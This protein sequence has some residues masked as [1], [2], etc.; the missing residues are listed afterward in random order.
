MQNH[1]VLLGDNMYY[2]EKKE[3]VLA[4]LKSRT[5]GLTSIEVNERFNKNKTNELKKTKHKTIWKILINQL[6]DAMVLIL[7]IA[8]ILSFI[9]K[10]NL[11]GIIILIIIFIDTII[12]IMQEYKAENAI[13]SLKELS[14]NYTKVLRNNN[15]TSVLSKNI[16]VGDIIVL[17]EGDLIPA[18]MRLI[19]SSGLRVIESSLTGESLAVNKNA[20]V[21]LDSST[22]LADRINM[23]YAS[24]LVTYGHGLGIVTKIG[25][26]TEVGHIA[27]ML[28]NQGE[29][30]TPLKKK[31]ESVG[32]ILSIIG[33]V[34]CAMLFI[35][36]IINGQDFE[37][38]LLT[39]M[40]LAI[41]IIPE[42]LPATATIVLAIGVERMAKKQVLI[43][44]L[45]SVETLGS[46]SVICSDKTGTLTQNKMN[47]VKI[48]TNNKF[49]LEKCMALCNNVKKQNNDFIGDPTEVALAE[50]LNQKYMQI[51]NIYERLKEL[52]FDS[53]RKKMT[54]LVKKD[55][56][57]V[58]TK[59]AAEEILPNCS[60]EYIENAKEIMSDN[61][62]KEII[63]KCNEF[64][65]KACRVLVF[66]KKESRLNDFINLDN[67]LT[68]IGLVAMVDPPR[69]DV[70]NIL[71][72]TKKA[73]IRTAIITGDNPLTA[74]TVAKEIGA[75]ENKAITGYDLM[76]IDDKQLGE[77]TKNHNIFARV[78]PY[79]KLRIVKAFKSNGEVVAMIGDGVNDAPSLKAA[80]I[81]IA[82]G[83]SGTDVAKDASDM[84]LL[85][86]D[87]PSLVDAIFEG[88]K[89]F[90]NI[91]K[92]IQFL[93][94]GNVGEILTLVIAM[95]LGFRFMPVTAI[96]ILWVNLATDT[97]PALALGVDP[98]T[99]DILLEKPKRNDSFLDKSLIKR[100]IFNGLI[101]AT[102]TLLSYFLGFR[103]NLMAGYDFDFSNVK[104]QTMAFCVLAFSQLIHS[105]NQRSNK[106]SAF[107][108]SN[109]HNKYLIASLIISFLLLFIIL[110]LPFF[111]DVFGFST[112][113]IKEWALVIS[114]SF[115]PLAV[116]EL[117][118]LIRHFK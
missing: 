43:R 70:K 31:L 102:I 60:Y 78:S 75:Y 7:F 117:I 22:P 90:K 73:G 5:T 103:K 109:G 49:E 89:V 80:D 14:P 114:F 20:D 33:I 88:R 98:A 105:F 45:P 58:F 8:S 12:G 81:G 110:F 55:L 52:A 106:Y 85:N 17:E 10:D 96:Q 65:F 18:D 16:I 32:K 56:Y 30:N 87:F 59:G 79:D 113:D 91:Q 44:K 82:M 94:A 72:K 39:S 24:S 77:L 47:V 26:D 101:I 62:K 83:K 100:V 108:K 19:S 115:V 37:P 107:S 4:K 95:L 63:Q 66:A 35:I 84:I 53:E 36:G 104:G 97:L 67:N 6:L 42:G 41:S 15:I 21:I 118:K 13:A 1:I 3:L 116:N 38:L 69:E 112:L 9:M 71:L 111:Q 51:N 68:Y 27:H 50:Y 86:D 40:A 2:D 57:E 46:T 34:L 92:V 93:L 25:M 28:S 64:A 74:E 76:N 23:A 29:L 11:E 61:R 99:K 48:V 54:V